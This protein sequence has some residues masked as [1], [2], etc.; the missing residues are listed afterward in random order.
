QMDEMTQ[1]NAALVEEASAAGEAMASQA[2]GLLN[3]MAYFTIE[4]QAN[5][6]QGAMAATHAVAA[7]PAPVRSARSGSGGGSDEWE[8]F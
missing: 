4:G 3:L 6:T 1:Q 8:D 7:G 5:G 2:K